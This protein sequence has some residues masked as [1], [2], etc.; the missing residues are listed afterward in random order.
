M[1]EDDQPEYTPEDLERLGREWVDRLK[2]AEKREERWYKDAEKAEAAYLCDN[3]DVA[4]AEVP[5]FNILHS[6]V[7]TIVP[8]IYNSTPRPDIRPRHNADDKQA[9][10]IADLHERVIA[11]LID[12]NRLDQEVESNAQDA[13]MAGRGIVRL[14]FDADVTEMVAIDESGNEVPAGEQV[15]NERILFECVSWRDY[16]EGPAQRWEYVPW[17]GYRHHVSDEERERLENPEFKVEGEKKDQ[18][19]DCPVWE[20]WCKETRKVYFVVE[21]TATVLDIIDDPLGLKGFFPQGKPIQP[22]T[23]TGK[24]MPVCPYTVYKALA[25]EIDTATRRIRKIMKGLRVRGLIA[26]DA[27]IADELAA[28]DDN[29]IVPLPNMENLGAL[30]GL[31]KAIA[32]WPADMA[33]AVLRELYM[34]REQTKQAIY[35]ITGISDIV[36]GQGAASET[37][38]AQQIKTQWGSLRIKKMQ[39]SIERQIRD[40]FVL[41]AE[42]VSQHFTRETVEKMAGMPL[43][44]EMPQ[45]PGMLPQQMDLE[46]QFRQWDGF[47]IDVETDSTVRADLEKNRGEMSE[48]LQGTAQFFQTMAPIVQQ[49]PTTAGPMAKMYAAFAQQ[50]NLGKSAEDALDQFIQMAEQASQQPQGPSPEQMKEE[51]EAKEAEARFGL[52]SKKLEL[53]V[54]R[55]TLEQQKAQAEHGIKVAGVELDRDKLQLEEAKAEVEAGVKL[56]EAETEQKER[57]N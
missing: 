29:D 54:A 22:V 36:R 49:A 6:N 16:R 1:T 56:I 51:R 30:G 33:I 38:T 39:R 8:A 5:D 9:K 43:S 21:E 47:R 15:S 40:I 25:E 37:A 27:S 10:Y 7:E 4:G 13:F 48:F 57:P 20:I 32:W 34:E 46:P 28:A 50:F 12:D 35:E 11:A 24:R 18:P 52:D 55:L 3:E 53:D 41:V 19:K 26:G 14:K 42:I 2:E 17:V 23:G 31:D 45:Q 44:M